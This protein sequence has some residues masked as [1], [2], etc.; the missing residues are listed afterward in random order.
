MSP[1]IILTCMLKDAWDRVD[2][3]AMSMIQLC[4][5]DSVLLDVL[6]E[7]TTKKL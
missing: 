7:D 3:K 6:G 2:K 4:L 1:E 5:T